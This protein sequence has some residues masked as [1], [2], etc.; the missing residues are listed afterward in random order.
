MNDRAPVG[1]WTPS[2]FRIGS[3]SVEYITA[4]GNQPVVRI[5]TAKGHILDVRITAAGQLR[6]YLNGLECGSTKGSH[7]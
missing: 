4:I 1:R 7:D 2:G 5:K 3:T 6:A